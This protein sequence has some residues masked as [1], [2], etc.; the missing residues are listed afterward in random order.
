MPNPCS[1]S[2][3]CNVETLNPA[4]TGCSEYHTSV[5][6]G[7]SVNPRSAVVHYANIGVLKIELDNQN[8]SRTSEYSFGELRMS[9][10]H[11][12]YVLCAQIHR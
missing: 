9:G 1:S 10:V 8:T 6:T 5:G 2:I 3:A 7:G 4:I 12:H 11:M